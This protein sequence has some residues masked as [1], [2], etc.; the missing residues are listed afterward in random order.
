MMIMNLPL[1][2]A[3]IHY[4]PLNNGKWYN[5]F[6]RPTDTLLQIENQIRG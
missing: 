5:V 1:F 3:R 6:L 4:Q 2:H